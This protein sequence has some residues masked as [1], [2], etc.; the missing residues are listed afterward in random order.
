MH[1]I[2]L[3]NVCTRLG[4]MGGKSAHPGCLLHALL[5]SL[6][7]FLD[8]LAADRAGFT[9]GQVTVVTVGQIDAHFLSC[10]HLE[11]VHSLASLGNIDLIVIGIAHV[12]TL[13]CFL[14][15]PTLSEES[16]FCFRRGIFTREENKTPVSFRKNIKILEIK[17][18][19]YY[20]FL[21]Y[22]A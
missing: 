17:E 11:A 21:F 6:D 1:R 15:K 12:S 14:R 19:V 10:L 7:H 18:E 20:H 8:H 4:G 3:H 22:A 16:V 9:G 13:L 5:V 2:S